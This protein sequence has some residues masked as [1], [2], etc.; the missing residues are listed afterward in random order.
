MQKTKNHLLFLKALKIDH[1][2]G[3]TVV[4]HLLNSYFDGVGNE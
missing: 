4:I 3:F 1:V 2:T